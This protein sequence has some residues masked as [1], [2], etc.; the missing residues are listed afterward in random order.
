MISWFQGSGCLG[1]LHTQTPHMML[2][3]TLAHLVVTKLR[4]HLV[5]T[6]LR[7]HRLALLLAPLLLLHC[8]YCLLLLV[9]SLH[10]TAHPQ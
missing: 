4:A 3:L 5:V 2:L 9:V 7:A 1:L 6:K 8:Y 10:A